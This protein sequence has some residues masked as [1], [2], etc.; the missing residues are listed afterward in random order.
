MEILFT[1]PLWVP[2]TA[3]L[4]TGA[5]LTMLLIQPIKGAVVAV[6]W[7]MGMDGFAAAKAARVRSH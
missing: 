6:Q 4:P 7:R 5:A 1:P 3:I 2:L